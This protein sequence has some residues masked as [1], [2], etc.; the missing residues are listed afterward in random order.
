MAKLVF[1][2]LP[3]DLLVKVVLGRDLDVV[4]GDQLLRR[5]WFFEVDHHGILEALSIR[6]DLDGAD[7][8]EFVEGQA[9]GIVLL[10]L[11]DVGVEHLFGLEFLAIRPPWAVVAKVVLGELHHQSPGLTLAV[12]HQDITS[13]IH[14]VGRENASNLAGPH[15]AP[16]QS[17]TILGP[18]PAAA[19]V[20]LVA[21][22]AEVFTQ[23][24]ALADVVVSRPCR[25]FI[26]VA[27]LEAED[28]GLSAARRPI[29]RVGA[30][31]GSRVANEAIGPHECRRP[32]A[33]AAI[34][35]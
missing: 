26:A 29:L 18:T 13:V 21:T 16:K 11:W 33:A 34:R 7:T 30:A 4:G 20:V 10:V 17:S 31:L 3:E 32:S 35:L 15:A 24:N 5:S 8:L 12:A 27:L 19:A 9:L 22:T 2:L 1:P 6:L 23:T 28:A 25:A 14:G